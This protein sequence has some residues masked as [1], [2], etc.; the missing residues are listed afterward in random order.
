MCTR[1]PG[2][3]LRVPRIATG[4]D[5]HV[6]DHGAAAGAGLR[7]LEL[8]LAV[9]LDEDADDAAR[10]ERVVDGAKRVAVGLAAAHRE[11]AAPGDDAARGP[12][13]GRAPTSP[14]SGSCAAAPGR[15]TGCP[16]TTRGWRRSA[17]GRCAGRARRPCTRGR[18]T[19]ADERAQHEPQPPP[20]AVVA[21]P[22]R[23]R[24]RRR[25]DE[26]EHPLDRLGHRQLGR[27][28]HVGVGRRGELLGIAP[29]ARGDRLAHLRRRRDPGRPP[30]A[31]PGRRAMPSGTP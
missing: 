31:R 8:G 14:C 5:R 26:P 24:S 25:L 17:P 12:G 18:S 21:R 11:G 28:D 20:R 2:R 30:A 19:H 23:P 7:A 9:A 10:R 27:V 13:R 3:Q 6:L 29:V 4:H 16:T 22:G 1:R 15:P